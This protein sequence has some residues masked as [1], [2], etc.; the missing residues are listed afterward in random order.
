MDSIFPT[1]HVHLHVHLHVDLA[2]AEGR[3][4]GMRDTRYEIGAPLVRQVSPDTRH[5]A[6][7]GQQG[8]G[9]PRPRHRKPPA[10]ARRQ[11]ALLTALLVGGATICGVAAVSYLGSGGWHATPADAVA[12]NA[13][14]VLSVDRP[15]AAAD[16]DAT[17]MPELAGQP[18]QAFVPGYAA[19]GRAVAAAGRR[20]KARHSASPSPSPSPSS[21]A[22]TG[23][24]TPSTSP[25]PPPPAA[26]PSPSP[27][28]AGGGGGSCA[29]P[30]F[31]TSAQFGTWNLSPYFVANDMWNAGAG[32]VSQTLSAC[33]FSDWYVTATASG[34]GGVLTYPDSHLDLDNAPKISSLSSATSTFADVNPDTGTYEDAYDIW[35]NGVADPSAGSD[36]LMIWTNN[37]GQTPG[38]SPMATVTIGGQS[39]TAWKGNGGYMA[40]VANSNIT[41]G[42]VNLLAFFQWV[43]AKGWVPGDSTLNQVDYGV[44]ICS[45]NG[46]PATFSFSD[47]S[48]H[49]N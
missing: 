7:H 5:S 46:A 41:S 36:E 34:G 4:G 1:E 2:G 29:D 35:L 40:F 39:W 30:S 45:T 47:F 20:A 16:G 8:N 27:T 19:G 17:A 26:S 37:H 24:P 21:S 48:V 32:N 43:I 3:S 23:S 38:G 6:S 25:S 9:A 10:V 28:S 42:T 49:V 31:T 12:L 22:T 18:T 15:D 33:S 11:G 13:G 44:E 14:A